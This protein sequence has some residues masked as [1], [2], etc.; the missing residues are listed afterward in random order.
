MNKKRILVR[1]V[2]LALIACLCL[3]SACQQKTVEPE[4]VV[5]TATAEPTEVPALP[6]VVAQE[7]FN[8]AFSPFFA[9]T[10]ADANAMELTQLSMLT[11]D[12]LG[13]IVHHAIAGE[14]ISYN[15]KPY[16]YKGPCDI[17]VSYDKTANVTT[18]SIKLAD[19]LTFS[20]GKPVTADDVIFTYYVYA[21]PS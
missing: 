6:L 1:V 17:D 4:P 21:D 3:S 15:G 10:A 5:A 11:T 2:L 12:R 19:G 13:N 7:Q 16:T 14:T 18:Y 20:D 8:E 9:V